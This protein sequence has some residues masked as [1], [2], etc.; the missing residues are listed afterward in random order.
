MKEVMNADF[1][2]RLEMRGVNLYSSSVQR[3]KSV[4]G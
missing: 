1:I 2:I 3:K 4:H